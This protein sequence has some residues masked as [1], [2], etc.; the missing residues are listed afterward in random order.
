MGETSRIRPPARPSL[1]VRLLQAT[2]RRA[3]S[4]MLRR[5]VPE[6]EATGV[7]ARLPLLAP[8]YSLLEAA[9]LRGRNLDPRLAELA[10]ARTAT[11]HGCPW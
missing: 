6:P 4:K 5:P 1:V 11:I 7:M 8:G 3:M 9:L 2:T 10:R